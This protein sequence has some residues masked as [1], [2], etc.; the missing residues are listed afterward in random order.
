MG[1]IQEIITQNHK[2]I[3]KSN[4]LAVEN[5]KLLELAMARSAVEAT[6]PKY[7]EAVRNDDRN[8]V[9]KIMLS[10]QNKKVQDITKEG[11]LINIMYGIVFGGQYGRRTNTGEI[12]KMVGEWYDASKYSD[13]NNMTIDIVRNTVTFGGSYVVETLYDANQSDINRAHIKNVSAKCLVVHQDGALISDLFIFGIE[14]S[15]LNIKNGNYRIGKYTLIGDKAEKMTHAERTKMGSGFVE[16]CIK[17]IPEDTCRKINDR[18]FIICETGYS[19]EVMQLLNVQVI[20]E[21]FRDLL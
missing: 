17:E 14:I 19:D 1:R 3:L 2:N 13:Y 6:F 21:G 11:L 18:E 20:D 16:E 7:V 4:V 9:H 10:M 8:F 12:M 15:G 5:P